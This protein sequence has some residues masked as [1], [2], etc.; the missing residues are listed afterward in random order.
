MTLGSQPDWI[1]GIKSKLDYRWRYHDD[2]RGILTDNTIFLDGTRELIDQILADKGIEDL[3]DTGCFQCG[4]CS[5][6]C[7]YGL[8]NGN[9][10]KI[11][12][13]KMVHKAQ[14]GISDFESDALWLCTTCNTCVEQCPRGVGTVELVKNLRRIIVEESA[15]YYPK[16]VRQAA[17]NTAGAGNPLGEAREKRNDWVEDLDVKPFSG[18]MDL[19]FFP[20]CYPSYDPRSRKT[21][22]AVASILQK[23]GVNF[24]I[25]DGRESCCGESMRKTGNEALFQ[26]LAQ[27]NVSIFNEKGVKKILVI[28]P[29]CY[30]TFKHEYPELSEEFEVIHFTQYLARLI[31]EGRLRLDKKVNSRVAYHDPCYLGRHNGIYEEPRQ[32]LQSIPGLE[33]VEMPESRERSLCCGGGGGGI[34]MDT[35]KGERLADLRLEQAAGTG[36]DILAVACPYCLINFEDS[37]LSAGEDSCIEVKDISE[38]VLDAI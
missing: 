1:K 18:E 25:L 26:N 13:R 14:L 24:G 28:S 32:V 8:F 35:K 6:V 5:A 21:A 36:A 16:S 11:S 3:V 4:T 29:H 38:L 10:E 27:N 33:L 9:G 7:P 31:D 20:G 2:V 34:W 23:A 12:I 37:V 17:V 22:R 30:H 15:G 19:L